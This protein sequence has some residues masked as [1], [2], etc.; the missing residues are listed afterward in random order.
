MKNTAKL[1]LDTNTTSAD[2]HELEEEPKKNHR[3]RFIFNKYQCNL[4]PTVE[5][6]A[7]KLV[8][9]TEWGHVP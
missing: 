2:R 4:I 7:M 3:S 1:G 9:G 5:N 8:D 6:F